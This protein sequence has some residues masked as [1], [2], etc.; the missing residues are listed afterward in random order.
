MGDG[1]TEAQVATILDKLGTHGARR[2]ILLGSPEEMARGPLKAALA[3]AGIL[4]LVPPERDR[5]W[6]G[7]I[8]RDELWQ[9]QGARE[10]TD[11]LTTLLLDG[12]E[13]GVSAILVTDEKLCTLVSACN[14]PIPVVF[15]PKNVR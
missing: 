10:V 3:K 2:V 7:T 11:Y 8:M 6:L 4:V 9:C 14:L 13:H 5:A 1:M 15:V 12:I